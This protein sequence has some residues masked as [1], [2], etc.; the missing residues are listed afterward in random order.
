MQSFVTRHWK[1]LL[2]AGAVLVVAL[3]LGIGQARARARAASPEE[4]FGLHV[5]GLRLTAGGF[6][7]D[8]RLR[9]IDVDKAAAVLEASADPSAVHLKSGQRLTVPHPPRFG[10]LRSHSKAPA[11]GQ[12]HFV[13]FGNPNRLAAAGDKVSVAM[14]E[15][16]LDGL[17]V[18]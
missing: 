9:V 10:A 16:R 3:G 15:L 12:V 4:R 8:L 11:A 18:E 7:L 5:E 2:A 1:P 14:G 17:T 13:L 6:A